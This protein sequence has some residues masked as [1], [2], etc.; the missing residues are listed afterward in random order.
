MEW[1][2]KSQHTRWHCRDRVRWETRRNAGELGG[3]SE[4]FL[5]ILVTIRDLW[6]R[7]RRNLVYVIADK[8]EYATATMYVQ[9]AMQQDGKVD[10]AT[11]VGN[12][13]IVSM[14]R[15]P[16]RRNNRVTITLAVIQQYPSQ[17]SY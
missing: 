13:E 1:Q 4:D 17:P 14:G 16:G 8:S 11:L 2:S 9:Y 10:H 7:C 5:D 6:M 12:V 15:T 3:N